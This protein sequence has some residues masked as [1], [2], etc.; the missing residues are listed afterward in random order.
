[1]SLWKVRQQGQS[2]HDSRLRYRQKLCCKTATALE[3]KNSGRA[4][5]ADCGRKGQQ[6]A[7]KIKIVIPRW[8]VARRDDNT[9]IR[10]EA[11]TPQTRDRC[12]E[13]FP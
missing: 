11:T 5:Q 12:S 6:F 7:T 4:G 9:F 10:D 8:G 3:L 2:N 1:M 13:R